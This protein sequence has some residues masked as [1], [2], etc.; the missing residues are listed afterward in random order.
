MYRTSYD[1]SSFPPRMKYDFT[2]VTSMIVET[3]STYRRI[4][5]PITPDVVGVSGMVN[6][7]RPPLMLKHRTN[8]HNRDNPWERSVGGVCSVWDGQTIS[9]ST[10]LK[11]QITSTM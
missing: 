8:H 7:S 4:A 2:E 1:D 10:M 3:R 9:R 11:H 6:I 5:E